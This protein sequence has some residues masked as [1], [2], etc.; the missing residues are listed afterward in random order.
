M[1][2]ETMEY[3]YHLQKEQKIQVA[4]WIDESL[5]KDLKDESINENDIPD[6]IEDVVD[7]CSQLGYKS[8]FSMDDEDHCDT[9]DY[10]R[11]KGI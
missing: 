10:Y 6:M 4:K 7:I 8:Y 1:N 3:L 11:M 5:K 2:Y 9:G